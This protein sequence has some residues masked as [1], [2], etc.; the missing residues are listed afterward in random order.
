MATPLPKYAAGS[1][2]NS[3]R[4]PPRGNGP[5]GPPLGPVLLAALA[6]IIITVPKLKPEYATSKQT[7]QTTVKNATYQTNQQPTDSTTYQANEEQTVLY[8]SKPEA[9]LTEMF[10]SSDYTKLTVKLKIKN[11]MAKAIIKTDI[12]YTVNDTNGNEITS[13]SKTVIQTI[14]PNA[15]YEDTEIIDLGLP[16]TSGIQTNTSLLYHF[17]H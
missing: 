10:L 13:C 7:Q 6:A 15:E 9:E 5:K 14:I 2:M 16:Q 8:D 17:M 11:T 3:I 4:R 12:T 1:N